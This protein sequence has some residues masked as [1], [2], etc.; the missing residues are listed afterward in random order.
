MSPARRLPAVLLIALVLAAALVAVPRP[1]HAGA[2][3]VYNLLNQTRTA[4]GLPRLARNASLDAVAQRW[5]Q[6]MLSTGDF[7]H[8]PNVGSEIPGGWQSWGE[9][10]AMGYRTDGDLH[11]AWMNSPGHR[12]NILGGFNSVGIG[13][14]KDGYGGIWATQVFATYPGV[15]SPAAPAP[16]VPVVTAIA[17]APSDP[18][19]TAGAPTAVNLAAFRTSAGTVQVRRISPDGMRTSQDLGGGVL[20]EPALVNR[21]GQLEV[22]VRG[23][24]NLLY[25][26]RGSGSSWSRWS[27]VPGITLTSAPSVTQVGGAVHLFFR[28]GTGQLVRLVSPGADRYG[29]PTSLGGAVYPSAAPAVTNV[30]GVVR[31][32]VIGTD[33]KVWSKPVDATSWTSLGGLVTALDAVVGGGSTFVVGRG[34]NG[35]VYTQRLGSGRWAD[36]AGATAT[37]P[38]A[39]T[40]STGLPV[41][42]VVGT[43][44]GLYLAPLDRVGA[45]TRVS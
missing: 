13:W 38:V 22:Y 14:V 29:T 43:N 12:A 9:N 17:P 5:T 2:S 19:V 11:Q 42:V 8:N 26:S 4:Q 34:T 32:H 31:V 7:R 28:S 35:K 16:A 3:D 21:G 40:S 36:L 15:T 23:T 20:G 1:A 39:G 44:G 25:V 33:R 45:W 41:S 30:G 27:A 24:N 18:G 37:S 6:R 10:I